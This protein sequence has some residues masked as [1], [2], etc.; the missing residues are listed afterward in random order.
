MNKTQLAIIFTFFFTTLISTKNHAQT[1]T[2]PTETSTKDSTETDIFAMS[3]DELMNFVVQTGN[4]SGLKSSKNPIAIT[5]ISEKEIRISPAKNIYDLIEIYVPGLSVTEHTMGPH[6]A[7]RGFSG[8]RNDKFLLLVNGK[9]MNDRVS[10]GAVSEL[11][12]WDLDDIVKVEV[13]R[14]PGSIIYGPGAIAGVISLTTRR[15]G[16]SEAISLRTS[17]NA[18]YNS[19][20]ASFDMGFKTPDNNLSAYFYGSIAKTEGTNA[21]K[22][23]GVTGDKKGLDQDFTY[24]YIGDETSKWQDDFYKPIHMADNFAGPQMKLF[25]DL[26][27]KKNWKSSFRYTEGGTSQVFGS[28]ARKAVY[29]GDDTLYYDRLATSHRQ[30]TA[31]LE[32]FTDINEKLSIQTTGSFRAYDF[33]KKKFDKTIT[34]RRFYSD[35]EIMLNSILR[36]SPSEKLKIAGGIEY[37]HSFIGKGWGSDL[38]EMVFGGSEEIVSD[39]NALKYSSGDDGYY[40]IGNGISYNII[41]AFCEGNLSIH[42]HLDLQV[43]ARFD[44]HKWASPVF[45]PKIALISELNNN[46]VIKAYWQRSARYL[47][48]ETMFIP[49]SDGNEMDPEILS[50]TE[51]MYS[52]L[53]N[54][55]IL[56]QVGGFYNS[57]ELIGMDKNTSLGLAGELINLGDLKTYG[58]ELEAEYKTDKMR[59]GL[60]HATNLL[61]SW[62]LGPHTDQQSIQGVSFATYDYNYQSVDGNG[63]PYLSDAV[64]DEK[65][66]NTG[67]GNSINNIPTHSTKLFMHYDINDKF[68]VHL[69]SRVNWKYEGY[70]DGIQG[71]ENASEAFGIDASGIYDDLRARN[72]GGMD[73]RLNLGASYTFFNKLDVLLYLQNIPVQGKDSNK[74]YFYNTGEKYHYPV[75]NYM[76]DVF[77]FSMKVQYNFR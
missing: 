16:D 53:L 34:H 63:D 22:V 1:T 70:L 76:L 39:T 29:E 19:S 37:V 9:F 45:S 3:L 23:Y 72:A 33:N 41:S 75:K 47:N 14:G 35:Q 27:Y 58:F 11:N 20:R 31:I 61:H 38:N 62:E 56:L 25:L 51:I 42:K 43:A 52:N 15:A 6:P 24:G 50:T 74:R 8:I 67:I 54:D 18:P 66:H 64:I 59:I 21:A 57:T 48:S 71:T 32:N 7:I 65:Y 28:S 68:T 13:I 49:F 2:E 30:F 46:Q 17:Y 12:M 73:L 26:N 36:Y 60:N 40:F 5:T 10:A 77:T 69:D 55:K 44:D 4:L